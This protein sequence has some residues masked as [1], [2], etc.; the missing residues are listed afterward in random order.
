MYEKK[1]KLTNGIVIVL[2]VVSR[3][4]DADLDPGEQAVLDGVAEVDPLRE[5]VVG[6]V[7]LEDGPHVTVVGRQLDGVAGV[8]GRGRDLG[9]QV[10][11]PE[12]L[13]D[14]A[15]GRVPDGDG[16]VGHD[17]RVVVRQQVR[18][19]GAPAVVAREDG[20]EAG[21]AV[22]V[23]QLDAAEEGGVDAG[24]AGGVDAR[25]DARGVAVPDVDGDG[26]DRRARVDVDVLHLEEDVDAVAPLR[27][28]DVGAHLLAHDV[29]GAHGDLG[30]QDTAR[31][32]AEDLLNRGEHV[33][34]V[35]GRHVVVDSLP[36]LEVSE[37][38]LV[39]S[40]GCK[41]CVLALLMRYL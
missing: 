34:V 39:L 14:V 36:C 8:G 3:A 26:G 30:R 40:R 21:D 23:G 18:V 22:G 41:K 5:G 12:Q 35:G 7:G 38:A 19:H 37:R 33:V 32:G 11:G 4:V 16:A 1:K 13:P 2:G 6:L 29:V 28:L 20:L 31:V 25:V 15:H 24:L 27:L 9:A 17:G 10:L